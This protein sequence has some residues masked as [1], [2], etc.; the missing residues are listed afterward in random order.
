[1]RRLVFAFLVGSSSV[2]GSAILVTDP[3]AFKTVDVVNWS[4][5]SD[6]T[7]L[8]QAFSAGSFFNDNVNG[9]F[10]TAPGGSIVVAGTDVKT[11][12]AITDGDSLVATGGDAPLTLSTGM[13]DPVYGMGAYIEGNGPG[14]FTVRIQAF[15]GVSS[16]LDTTVTSDA[17]GDPVFVGAGDVA[18]EITSVVYSLSAAPAGYKT[19]DFL[20]DTLL[21]QKAPFLS[22]QGGLPGPAPL[23]PLATGA[24]E[25]GMTPLMAAALLILGFMLKKRAASLKSLS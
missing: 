8:T 11:K 6:Q 20:L 24:P 19:G 7:P 23:P 18:K 15:V 1:M 17:S 25:P 5:Y 9:S 12:G 10:A 16:V 21:L 13:S 14:Q 2:Y 22:L 3:S 4:Q